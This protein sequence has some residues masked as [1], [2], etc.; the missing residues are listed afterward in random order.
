MVRARQ[1]YLIPAYL[2]PGKLFLTLHELPFSNDWMCLRW[3]PL[4]GSSCPSSSSRVAA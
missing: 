3:R 1:T 2:P 4:S